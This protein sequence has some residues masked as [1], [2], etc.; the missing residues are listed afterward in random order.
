MTVDRHAAVGVLDISR[1][2]I[3]RIDIG[4]APGAV[5]DAVGLGGMFVAF[6][7]EDHPQPIVRRARSASR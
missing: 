4:D 2:Q 6:V 5:D 3:Q 7:G 1:S